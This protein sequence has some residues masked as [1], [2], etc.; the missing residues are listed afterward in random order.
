MFYYHF[1][2]AHSGEGEV[3]VSSVFAQRASRPESAQGRVTLAWPHTVESLL[4]GLLVLGGRGDQANRFT[5]VNLT[6]VLLRR[7]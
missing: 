3:G 7:R 5:V 2:G 4:L 1:F 6:K